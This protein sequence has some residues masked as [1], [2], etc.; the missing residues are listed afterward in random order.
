MLISEEMTYFHGGN[1]IAFRENDDAPGRR[2]NDSFDGS[3]PARYR[4]GMGGID[5]EQVKRDQRRARR[6]FVRAMIRRLGTLQ[7]RH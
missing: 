6:E 3:I 5:I 1:P 7:R 4:D 2:V